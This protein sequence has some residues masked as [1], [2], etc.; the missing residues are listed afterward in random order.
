MDQL[1]ELYNLVKE[2]PFSATTIAAIVSAIG[3]TGIFSFLRRPKSTSQGEAKYFVDSKLLSPPMRRPAYS[4]RMSYVLA[5]MSALAYYEFEGSGGVVKDAAQ[6]MLKLAFDDE[7]KAEE[8]LE[9]FADELMIKGV[10]S[11]EFFKKILER[12]D[13]ELI[14]TIDLM[15][16][17]AFACKRV[18]EGESPYV[19]IAFRGTEK[20]FSDWLTDAR[21]LPTTDSDNTAGTR[22]HGGFKKALLENED[23]EARTVFKHV[24]DILDRPEAKDAAGKPLPVFITG[25]SLGGALALLTARELP[26][27]LIGACY[28]FGAPRVANYD[29]FKKT[30]TPVYRVVNSSD[31]VP[32]VPPGAGLALLLYFFQGLSWVTKFMPPVSALLERIESKLDR[33]KGYRH[34]GDLRHLTDVQ[35][36]R[37][38]KVELLSN[39]P[40][41]D[42]LIWMWENIRA[43][44][45]APVKSHGMAIYR[46]KLSEI[47][48]RRNRED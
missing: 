18:K 8:W 27:D 3:A 34:F 43:S 30:K 12:S 38:D 15:E 11:L 16:T 5:E 29:Y 6:T 40:A 1:V 2:N 42:R 14:D 47:A 23:G 4:D 33:L 41:I 24:E 48:N 45:F 22:V 31:I 36:G 17:Q 19:V 7:K 46:R 35:S 20:K 10:D 44:F 25:H 32:R 37:F 21:A 13:F 39:P 26:Q 28:T 9:T